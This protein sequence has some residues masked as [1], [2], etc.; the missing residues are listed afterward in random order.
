MLVLSEKKLF[1]NFRSK[2]SVKY[3]VTGTSNIGNIIGINI[4]SINFCIE[5][6]S[7]YKQK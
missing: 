5:Q 4:F 1:I 6:L 2:Y 7:W 3:K